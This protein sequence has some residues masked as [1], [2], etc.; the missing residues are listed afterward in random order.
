MLLQVLAPGRMDTRE[1]QVT[2]VARH[3]RATLALSY[4]PENGCRVRFGTMKLCRN[5]RQDT[6]PSLGMGAASQNIDG[7]GKL[8][9][10]IA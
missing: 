9:K 10:F 1:H 8:P 5:S 7:C 3:N 2:A 6:T 4:N